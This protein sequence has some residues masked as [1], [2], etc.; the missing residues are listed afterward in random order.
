MRALVWYRSDLRT[1]DN[2]ALHHA[3]RAAD[4]GVVALFVISPGEWEAH[5]LAPCRVDF[6]LRTLQELSAGLAALNIP[7]LIEEAALPGDVPGV[8]A[9]AAARHGCGAVYANREYEVNERRRDAAV[10]LLLAADGRAVHLFTDQIAIEP[11]EVRTGEGRFFTVFTPFKRAWITHL[12]ETRGGVRVLPAPNKQNNTGCTPAQV[13]GF[14]PGFVSPIPAERWP[15]GERHAQQRLR[16]FIAE[17][18]RAY[19]QSRDFPGEPGTSQL[20]PYLAVGAISPRQCFA[21]AA[22]ANGDSPD[23]YRLGNEGLLCW[24]SELI[25]RE[26][27]VHILAGFPRVCMNRPFQPR[28]ERIRWSDNRDHLEAWKR[29]R[30]GVPIVDAAMQQLLTTGWMH[31]RLRMISAMFLTKNLFIDWREGE[32]FFMRHLVDGFF[33]SNNGG[34]QWSASTGTDAAPYFRI[35]NPVSQSRRFDAS[36]TFIRGHIPALAGLDDESIH[37]PW[38]LSPLARARLTYPEP[39]VDLSRSRAAAIEAFAAIRD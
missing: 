32:R 18:G 34:W 5:D 21:A 31:N 14:V 3:C 11:G 36:G 8:V 29:G 39:L 2:T 6:M 4:E 25:W 30:T 12:L 7:L 15:A 17:R 35:F 10:S 23:P 22:E 9:R 24:I 13:P 38:E 26:F 19:K 37:A 27:Y 28:T 16:A 33:A 1:A 20:S